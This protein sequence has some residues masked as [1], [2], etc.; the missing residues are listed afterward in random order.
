[1]F[2][3]FH[4]LAVLNLVDDIDIDCDNKIKN[5]SCIYVNIYFSNNYYKVQILKKKTCLH[6]CGDVKLFNKLNI[7]MCYKTCVKLFYLKRGIGEDTE[8]WGSLGRVAITLLNF[9]ERNMAKLSKHSW[10]NRDEM[11]FKIS[12]LFQRNP[13]SKVKTMWVQLV[14]LKVL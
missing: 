8:G 4:H 2:I 3:S 12:Y 6:I 14:A 5:L 10:Y 1:M 9:K 11:K 13:S 7:K